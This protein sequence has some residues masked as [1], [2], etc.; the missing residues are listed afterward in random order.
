MKQ[1]I[2]LLLLVSGGLIVYSCTPKYAKYA[3]VNSRPVNGKA[4]SDYSNLDYWAAHP[5]KHD[6]SD[7]VPFPLR[8]DYVF[9]STVDVFFIHPTTFTGKADTA[10]NA[11][12][13]N[14][15]LNS[16]TDYSPILYQASAFNEWRVFAPRYRQAHIRSYYTRDSAAIRALELAYQD[17]KQAFQFYL[18]HYNQGRPII[19]ASH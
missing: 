2:Y 5:Y 16:K 6:P 15:S 14:G 3:S 1:R 9:D 10:W 12:L 11:Q 8:K 19:I 7:S 17:V 13:D 4:F 18:D